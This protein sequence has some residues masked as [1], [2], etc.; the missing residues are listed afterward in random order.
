MK[1][2]LDGI[3]QGTR[4]EDSEDSDKWR[5]VVEAAKSYMDYRSWKRKKRS[6]CLNFKEKLYRKV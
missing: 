3:S 5:G 6:Y 4:I 1:T 2:D